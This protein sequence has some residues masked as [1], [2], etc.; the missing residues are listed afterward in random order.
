MQDLVDTMSLI[1][2]V[3][4]AVALGLSAF[5]IINTTRAVV[6]QQIW[7]IGV[8]KVYGASVLDVVR[9]YL[10]AAVA[11]GSLAALVAIPSAIVA[12]RWTANWLLSLINLTGGALR[13]P[14]GVVMLQIVISLFLPAL[15][16]LFPVLGGARVTPREAMMS[17]G[18][19]DQE[20]KAPR[21]SL[22]GRLRWVPRPLSLSLRNAFRRRTRMLLTITTLIVAGVMFLT[23]QSVGTSLQGTLETLVD[24]LGLD[25]WIVF[26]KPE[27]AER[28]IET[29]SSIAGVAYAEVWD[30]RAAR[31]ALPTGEEAEIYV[32]G[33]PPDSPLFAPN[34]ATGRRLS[35]GDGRAILLN[36]RI[37]IE[38]GFGV[39]DE[40][41][42]TI[43]RRTSVW[44]VV[45]TVVS[46]TNEQRDCF[47][48][49][50]VL[51]R[52]TRT[53]NHGTVVM[54]KTST[55]DIGSLMRTLRD[56][57]VR[58]GLTPSFLLSAQEMRQQNQNQFRIIVALL[59][60]MAFMA[61]GVG[62]FGLMGTM[63]INVLER[64]REVGV[65]RAIGA[66]SA[67]VAGVFVVEGIAV[68]L[69]SWLVAVPLS[70]PSSILF[71]RLVGDALF[72][73]PIEITYQ[74]QGI[75][76][77][78]IGVLLISALASLLPALR[79]AGLRV[80]QVLRF[81]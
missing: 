1:L 31:L 81:E 9:I 8:M 62:A 68:G 16:A 78:L 19:G 23:I 75:A 47:V 74:F 18:L 65:M 45:G 73:V 77:W 76:F 3:L 44:T 29:A 67:T 57:F 71:G 14:M 49:L 7:Q 17:Y 59:L 4:G 11:Y 55:S 56:T 64:S 50:S 24:E 32:M 61:A 70:F 52:E 33:V 54:V 38:E 69:L 51:T 60:V 28:L 37:A 41:E 35:V 5:L 26:E 12:A 6:T 43:D 22:L 10:I 48:P 2:L 27:R 79:A 53:F 72:H 40:V 21:R 66:S 20:A 15:A 39:G 58:R 34:I 30:Q 25:V 36:H 46:I 13:V 42:V 63:S 80:V